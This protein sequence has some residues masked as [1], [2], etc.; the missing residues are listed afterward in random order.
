[1]RDQIV[2]RRALMAK[3]HPAIR[4]GLAAATGAKA[5]VQIR[6]ASYCWNKAKRRGAEN[7]EVRRENLI[8][9][10]LRFSAFSA[11]LR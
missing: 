8:E 9:T 2:V 5:F 7:A 1:M 3:F 10:P 11:P 4:A 6:L